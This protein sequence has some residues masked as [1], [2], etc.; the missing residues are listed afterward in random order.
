MSI[1]AAEIRGFLEKYPKPEDAEPAVK[2]YVSRKERIYD[3]SHQ[4]TI[5]ERRRFMDA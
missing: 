5:A 2:D 4:S 1:G 3:S